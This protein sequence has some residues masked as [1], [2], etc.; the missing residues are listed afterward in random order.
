MNEVCRP[1]ESVLGG[2]GEGRIYENEYMLVYTVTIL[3][4]EIIEHLHL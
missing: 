2:G 1:R 4:S 3:F